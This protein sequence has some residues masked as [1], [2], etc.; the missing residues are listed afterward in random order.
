MKHDFMVASDKAASRLGS[1]GGADDDEAVCWSR[2]EEK[3]MEIMKEGHRMEKGHH[4]ITLPFIGGR[5]E[6]AKV[7]P[8]KASEAMARQ[9]TLRQGER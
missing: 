9:R 3:A 5:R 6:A 8:R 7:L 1:L 4:V 2:N